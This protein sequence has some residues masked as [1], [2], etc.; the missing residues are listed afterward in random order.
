MQKVH[1]VLGE[2][3]Y[4]II[5]EGGSLSRVG[6]FVRECYGEE[7]S[8]VC[9][10]SSRTVAD[11]YLETVCNSLSEMGYDNVRIVIPDGEE[12]KTLDTYE[13]ITTQLIELRFERKSLIIPLGG[14]VVGDVSG[15]V[16]ATFLRGIPFIHVPTTIVAQVDSSIGGKVAVNHPLG[17]NLIGSFY[18]PGGVWIDTRVLSTLEH[19]EV[20]SGM[21]EAI[22]HAIIRDEGFF[23]FYEENLE[24]IMSFEATDDIMESFIAWNCR[25]KAEIVSADERESGLRSILNYGHTVGHALETV[26]DYGR[27]T[28]GD[29]VILGMFAAGRIAVRKGLMSEHDLNRQNRLLERVGINREIEGITRDDMIEAM[30][31]DK[32][33][34]GGRVRFALPHGIGTVKIHDDVTWDEIGDGIEYMI[35][36]ASGK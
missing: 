16:A 34:T 11:L 32:K 3:S 12:Q 8:R 29:A 15:F 26:T 28:H 14:G 2:R 36:Y 27:F 5:I 33:V 30:T 25:I 24:S 21:A 19:R 4:D 13:R 22:K 35:E 23:A 7:L 17:K 9:V 18:Q 1:V 10:I 31:R 20:V 6:S